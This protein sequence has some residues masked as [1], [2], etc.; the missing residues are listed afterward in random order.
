MVLQ[1]STLSVHCVSVV[2]ACGAMCVCGHQNHRQHRPGH[3]AAK[4]HVRLHRSAALQGNVKVDEC[5]MILF[6]FL[7]PDESTVTRCSCTKRVPDRCPHRANSTA[8]QT[9]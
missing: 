5:F 9:R 8:A 1:H 2:T 6:S 3:H 7:F 4:F